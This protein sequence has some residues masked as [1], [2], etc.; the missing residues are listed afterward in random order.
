MRIYWIYFL[1]LNFFH[2]ISQ[3]SIRNH[4]KCKGPRISGHRTGFPRMNCF[5]DVLAYDLAIISSMERAV[6]HMPNFRML[7]WNR[8]SNTRTRHPLSFGSR[9]P[10]F[11]YFNHDLI[12]SN[13]LRDIAEETTSQDRNL[14]I[15]SL[16]EIS[17]WKKSEWL[18][19]EKY[20]NLATVN[21][22]HS[23]HLHQ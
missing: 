20:S 18:F 12:F 13:V 9:S 7:V 14:L 22:S 10:A 6:L 5:N 2:N 17:C 23:L 1:L 3:D 8:F 15:N 19:L 4:L 11:E 21:W 16:S